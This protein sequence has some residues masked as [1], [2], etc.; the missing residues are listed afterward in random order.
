MTP[1]QL[2]TLKTYIDS[3]Q[4]LSSEPNNGDGDVAIANK[5]NNFGAAP[6]FFVW[7][8]IVPINEIM[9]NGF[10]WTLVDNLSVGKARIWDWMTTLGA[11]NPSQANVLAGINAAFTGGT[12]PFQA[13]RLAIFNHCQ[14]LATRGQKLY[15][16]GTGT[17][18]TDSGTGPG[19]VV[20]ST[21][22]PDDVH[23][24]RNP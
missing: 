11:I 10:D 8:T 2:G 15:T 21:I 22:T 5:L 13:M 1:A 14:T 3:Q 9:G 18:T 7:R 24:A 6:S 17:T 16:T 20:I 4:D 12:A 23:Q 19:L